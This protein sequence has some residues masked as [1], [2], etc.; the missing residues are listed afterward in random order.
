MLRD[1]ELLL[2]KVYDN[3]IKSYLLEA[4]KCYSAEAYRACVIIS[5]IGG[6]HD[7]HNKLKS[8]APSNKD[9]AALEKSV[10]QKKEELKPYERLLIDGC[11]KS[12]ID[13]LSSFEAKELNLCIDI[14]N[15][16]AHPSDYICTAEAARY[17]YSTIIDILASKPAL[18]GQQYINSLYNSI[19]SDTYFPRYDN[20]E[21]KIF[22]NKQLK[23]CS[24]RMIKPLA[25]KLVKGIMSESSCINNNKLFFLSNMSQILNNDFDIIIQ[26]LLLNSEFHSKIMVILSANTEI[27]SNLSNENIKRLLHIF[28]S[29]IEQNLGYN[30]IILEVLLDTK[31]SDT[32]YNNNIVELLN[33]NYDKM[34]D[35]QIDLWISFV[36]NKTS[37]K[38][39]ISQIKSDYINHVLGKS[40][41]YSQKHQEIFIL[42]DNENLYSELI[43]NISERIANYD[44]T[45]SNPAVWQLNEL[46]EKFIN[47]LSIEDINDIIYSILAGNQGFGREVANLLDNIHNRSFYKRY[48]K[49]T[50]P[51][52]SCDDFQKMMNYNL[53]CSTF[54][55]FV[56]ILS[57]DLANFDSIF[58]SVVEKYISN[59]CDDNDIYMLTSCIN[60]LR[61]ESTKS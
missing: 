41:F 60:K 16:C 11:A 27:I 1:M 3:E 54:C 8:L 53:N 56:D 49:E 39:R 22:V 59:N 48:F 36:N 13:L 18:L 20:D 23:L 4:L 34:T 10:S 26:P 9:I 51:V 14:R 46:S 42:C 44:Y 29:Y 43:R 2:N 52:F 30:Q 55:R 17:V 57:N 47:A 58:I 24:R 12:N 6:I 7:L 25:Q 50:V 37:S 31:L 33:Y 32:T 5:I 21:I 19:N 61:E 28:K 45:I 15:D 40:C 38:Q 35:N